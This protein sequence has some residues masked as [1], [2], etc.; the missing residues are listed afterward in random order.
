MGIK[1]WIGWIERL[2]RGERRA[3]LQ[4]TAY[5]ALLGMLAV[6]LILMERAG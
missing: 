2:A 4:A 3:K 5:C 1:G 6:G